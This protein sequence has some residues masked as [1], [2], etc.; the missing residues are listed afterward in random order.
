M[1]FAVPGLVSGLAGAILGVIAVL[2]ITA[3]A[4]QNSIPAPETTADPGSSV[5]GNVTYG[6]R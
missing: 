1:K 4:Q 2:G 3:G 6:S 5:L